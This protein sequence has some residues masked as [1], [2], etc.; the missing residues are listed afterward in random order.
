MK[1]G[2]YGGSFNPPHLGHVR[3]ALACREELGLDRVIV[4]PASTP[5]HKS[6]AA[7]S[8]TG[9]ERLELTKLAFSGLE[10]FT[11]SN[12]ELQRAGKSYTVDTVRT[13]RES[14]RE[15][16]L[17][18]MMGTDMF[19]SFQDWYQPQEIA[20]NVTL[21]CFSRFEADEKDRAALIS[22]KER[23]EREFGAKA[24][25]LQNDSFE[26]SSTKV[27]QLLFFGLTDGYLAPQVLERIRALGLYGVGGDYRSLSFD[28][29]CEVS[30]SLHKNSRVPHAMGVCQTSR[31]LA[32]RFGEDETLAARAGILHDVTKALSAREQL[33]LAKKLGAQLTSFERENPQLL[34]AKTGAAVAHKIFGENDAVCEAIRWHTTG[35]ADMTRLEKIIYLADMIEPNRSYPGI[36]RIRR[37]AEENL[38]EAVLLALD[39]SISFV[40]ER[41]LE[42]DEDSELARA[43]LMSERT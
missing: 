1:I 21:A 37:A 31:A 8:P 43:F 36:E 14:Y 16:E 33:D 18:L 13:L 15:D 17:V 5:P 4:I 7:H 22:Q 6:L 26:I 41:G 12:L 34:H 11:V 30:L 10:G 42:V 23:L 25:L 38:D 20:K 3:A 19:L 2:I 29:L 28:A 35:K 40:R 27:R 39:R 9:E 24:V 32:G